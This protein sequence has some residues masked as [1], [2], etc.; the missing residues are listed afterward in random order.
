MAPFCLTFYF[1]PG[2]YPL[3]HWFSFQIGIY[4]RLGKLCKWHCSCGV[5]RNVRPRKSE[6]RKQEEEMGWRGGGDTSS[7]ISFGNLQIIP[8]V[9]MKVV[10]IK[11]AEIH[12]GPCW[13]KRGMKTRGKI[14][15]WGLSDV[16]LK[17][18]NSAFPLLGTCTIHFGTGLYSIWLLFISS[19]T[20]MAVTQHILKM[21]TVENIKGIGFY[22]WYVFAIVRGRRR[23]SDN[24]F[25]Q[26]MG[27]WEP[28]VSQFFD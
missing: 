27:V 10:R 13:Y 11:N 18:T 20:S 25:V 14:S 2:K 16:I 12:W 26:Q 7:G 4:G 19:S 15:M 24:S 8:P 17:G 5:K 9:L 23:P 3:S 22:F 6:A 1:L 21:T 28:L